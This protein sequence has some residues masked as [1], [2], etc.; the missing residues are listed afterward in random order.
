M[1]T[2]IFFLLR[3]AIGTSLFGHGLAR[4][5]KLAGFSDYM[6]GNFKKS[7]LPEFLVLPF[8]YFLPVA[9]FCLGLL[10]LLGLFT[11]FSLILASIV[12]ILLVFGTC[13][14]EDWA[15]IP[16]QLIHVAFFAFLLAYVDTYNQ[17]SADARLRPKAR[18]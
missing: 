8:S 9:E 7:M 1:D 4:L 13:M 15:A 17:W 16:S 6:V 14:I 2:T 10:L 11:R 3:I 5:P 18:A 12:M